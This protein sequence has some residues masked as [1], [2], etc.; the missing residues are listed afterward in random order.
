MGIC[1]SFLNKSICR[2][3]NQIISQTKEQNWYLKTQVMVIDS[4][5]DCL[6][7]TLSFYCLKWL[8]MRWKILFLDILTVMADFSTSVRLH[9]IDQLVFEPLCCPSPL[10]N[11]ESFVMNWAWIQCV[12]LNSALDGMHYILRA[13]LSNLLNNF[14]KD[15]EWRK[16]LLK[17]KMWKFM[18]LYTFSKHICRITQVIKMIW[19]WNHSGNGGVPPLT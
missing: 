19:Q 2:F 17:Q 6:F 10:I 3:I 13:S 18:T 16:I 8:N 15:L 4:N 9:E 12:F 7:F 11:S 5:P 1:M 14:F